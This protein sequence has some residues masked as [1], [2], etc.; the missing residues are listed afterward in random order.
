MLRL[1]IIALTLGLSA[2]AQAADIQGSTPESRTGTAQT[3]QPAQG[4]TDQTSQTTTLQPQASDVLQKPA[5]SIT[6]Q[7]YDS[8]VTPTPPQPSRRWWL[9]VAAG[10]LAGIVTWIWLRRQDQG[11]VQNAKGT[12]PKG[13]KS[14][15]KS[16]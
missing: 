13:V 11:V 7:K 10:I 15:N 3:L 4:E 12:T 9:Y 1:L 16:G 8:S 14:T 6:V 2:G 5:S